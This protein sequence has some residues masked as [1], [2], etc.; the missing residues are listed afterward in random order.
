MKAAAVRVSK[1][2]SSGNASNRS[3]RAP[4]WS[5]LISEPST[6]IRSLTRTRWGEVANPILAPAVDR[7]LSVITAVEPLP[8]GPNHQN[9]RISFLRV[10]Q[11]PKGCRPIYRGWGESSQVG[12]VKELAEVTQACGEGRLQFVAMNHSIEHAVLQEKLRTLESLG[13]GL[14]DGLLDDSGAGKS[15]QRTRFGNIEVALAS[16]N[17]P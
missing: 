5:S 4:S 6:R 2:V 14:P 9:R 8:Y 13:K 15:D 12:G 7:I 3:R 16:Q 17:W 1:K 11:L 10:S